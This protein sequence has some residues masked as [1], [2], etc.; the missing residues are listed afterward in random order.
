M[1]PSIVFL[2]SP[3][4]DHND[5]HIRLP[6]AFSDAGWRVIV[7]SHDDVHYQHNQVKIAQHA[8][9]SVDL[10]WPIGFG[11]QHTF[12]DRAQLLG[13]IPQHY[14]ITPIHT[15][16]GLHG[17]SAW[18]DTAPLS[19]V[20]VNTTQL[21]EFAKT[22]GG[23]W[24]L[25]PP[26][27]SFGAFVQHIKHPDEVIAATQSRP[28]YWVLQR[29]IE[30]IVQGEVRTI[31]CGSKI[32]GSYRRIPQK[33]ALTANLAT[34][35]NPVSHELSQAEV[36]LVSQI[37]RDLC[38]QHVGFAAI[39]TCGG[40][41]IE[42][43]LANPGGLATLSELYHRDHGAEVVGCVSRLLSERRHLRSQE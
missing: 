4:T 38:K 41:L 32:I 33:G 15:L 40:Y 3:G 7:C 35:A 36:R 21:V 39:D 6:K 18:L 27:G 22:H 17:K 24:V 34:H 12:L 23:Q 25:K 8:A 28:G 29:Y 11:P 10:V 19:I 26:A 20:S 13:L 2:I 14:L 1:T 42:V 37:H 43:N 9:T 5:N 31:V 30:D 16:L